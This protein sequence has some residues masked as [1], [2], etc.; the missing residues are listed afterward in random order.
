MGRAEANDG[1]KTTF[2]IVL[3]FQFF[4]SSRAYTNKVSVPLV[5]S[6]PYLK[7]SVCVSLSY[8]AHAS[9][10]LALLGSRNAASVSTI[11]R[12]YDMP[13]LPLRDKI[14]VL[15]CVFI[16]SRFLKLGIVPKIGK[17]TEKTCILVK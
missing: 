15:F 2:L 14:P 12:R 16:L 4:A 17:K 6:V 10:A 9:S 8:S 1:S 11:V 3:A 5:F 7:V 13:I